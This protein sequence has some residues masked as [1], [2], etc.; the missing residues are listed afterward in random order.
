MRPHYNSQSFEQPCAQ[1][2]CTPGWEDNIKS[3]LNRMGM[4]GMNS[5]GPEYGPLVGSCEHRSDTRG[6]IK[7]GQ[8]LE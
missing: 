6:S 3:V 7:Y 8:C 1:D 2:L 4:C 5:C